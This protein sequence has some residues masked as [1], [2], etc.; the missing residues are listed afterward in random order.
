[1]DRPELRDDYESLTPWARQ[2][3]Q[4][5]QSPADVMQALYGVD[6]PAEAYAFDRAYASGLDLPLLR[7]MHPWELLAVAPEDAAPDLGDIDED[8]SA[9][10][11]ASALALWPQFLPLMRLRADDAT[12]GGHVIGYDLDALAEGRPTIWGFPGELRLTGGELA[13]LGPSL[14]AVLHT[15]LADHHDMLEAQRGAPSTS[16][17]GAVT[18]EDIAEAATQVQSIEALQR[19]VEAAR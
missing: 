15:W 1:M 2:L 4:E 13:V 18:D 6:L 8:W 12:H 14:L 10:H 17:L 7:L 11:E 19:E 3:Y 9:E 5:G 16:G